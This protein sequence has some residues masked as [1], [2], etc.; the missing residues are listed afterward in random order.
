[1]SKL[2]NRLNSSSSNNSNQFST[3][4]NRS[5]VENIQNNNQINNDDDS[6][7]KPSAKYFYMMNT[8]SLI[9]KNGY[10]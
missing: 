5:Q 9:R 7:F 2:S 6:K 4:L 8:P 1:M 10:F 3:N